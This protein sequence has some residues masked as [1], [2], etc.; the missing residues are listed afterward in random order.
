MSRIECVAEVGNL[1]G[2][3]VIWNGSEA[4]LY[5]VDAYGKLIQR[6]HPADGKLE[7]WPVDEPIG[8]LVFRAAGGIVAGMLSGFRALDLDAG[9]S[10]ILIDP[11]PGDDILLNDGKCDRAGRYWCGS[12]VM[13]LDRPDGVLWRLDP[14]L[15]AHAMD[16]GF[17]VSNG[18]AWS[19]DDRVMYFADTRAETVYAYDFDVTEGRISNRRV[20]LDTTR[21]EGRVDGATVDGDGFYWCAMVHGGAVHRYDPHGRLDRVI[22]LPVQHPTMCSFGGDDLSTLY[23]TSATRFLSPEE[24]TAQPEAGGLFAIHD[25]GVRGLPEPLFAG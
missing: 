15:R 18:I 20:F 6:Y 19:P 11:Q 24:R 2:E 3:G 13:S 7:S 16:R 5:W 23:V 4:A 9:T 8:S 25:L 22:E 1:L 10:E 21:T 12:V 14:D 17:L